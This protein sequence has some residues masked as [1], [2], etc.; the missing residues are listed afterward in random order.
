MVQCSFEQI[1]ELK[2]KQN[3]VEISHG[4]VLLPELNTVIK[5]WNLLH[6]FHI[7]PKELSASSFCH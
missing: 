3:P 1:K 6:E 7:V 5:V 4:P 2:C